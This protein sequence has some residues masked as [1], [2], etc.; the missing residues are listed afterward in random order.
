MIGELLHEIG[1]TLDIEPRE[2]RRPLLL[3]E[4]PDQGGQ[5]RRV[6]HAEEYLEGRSIPTLDQLFEVVHCATAIFGAI[7]QRQLLLS[8]LGTRRWV[9]EVFGAVVQCAF[10]SRP[11]S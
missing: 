9:L 3:I 10:R 6:E 7:E 4:E 8:S 11:V 5:I 2:N 1:D